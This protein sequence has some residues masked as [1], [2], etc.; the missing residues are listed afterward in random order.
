MLSQGLM[1]FSKPGKGI[2]RTP[3]WTSRG[4]YTKLSYIIAGQTQ[5]FASVTSSKGIA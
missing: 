4:K 5:N 3:H 2:L 1:P